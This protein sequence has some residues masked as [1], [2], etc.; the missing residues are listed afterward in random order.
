MELLREAPRRRGGQPSRPQVRPEGRARRGRHPL[1]AGGGARR[2]HRPQRDDLGVS[3]RRRLGRHRGRNRRRHLVRGRRCA[4]CSRRSRTAGTAPCTAGWRASGYD[5]TGHG[6]RG[7][8][9]VEHAVPWEALT[10]TRLR[11][12]V[13]AGRTGGDAR[14]AATAGSP[15]LVLHRLVR[16]ERPAPGP[17]ERH[18]H[19]LRAAHDRPA[20]SS[21]HARAAAGGAGSVSRPSHHPAR[22]AGHARAAGRPAEGVRRRVPARCPACTAPMSHPASEAG[23]LGEAHAA[24]EVILSGGAFNTPQLLMLSGIGPSGGVAQ[25]RHHRTRWRC[26]GWAAICRTATRSA[27]SREWTS[28]SGGSSAAPPSGVAMP[29]TAAGKTAGAGCMPPMA[30]SSPCSRDRPLPDA[31]PDLFVMAMVARFEG[32]APNYSASLGTDRN[33]LTWVV[34]KAHTK[35]TAGE[36]TLKSRGPPRSPAHQLPPV[37]GRR[38]RR[39]AGRW[40]TAC[41]S[42]DG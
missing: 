23:E 4:A 12:V 42:C 25:T 3:A 19:S 39:P 27:S 9:P 5:V 8:L 38:R 11:R 14:G 37:G 2:L 35:N 36:V 30:P 20:P 7:W 34:L 1:S 24:R 41:G 18:R 40:P 31:L 32:Y 6:W 16:S 15:P 21:R 17:R 13:I 33:F 26:R 28:P 22:D 29:P 10:D